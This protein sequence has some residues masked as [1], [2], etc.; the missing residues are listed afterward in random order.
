MDTAWIQVFVLMFAECTAPVGKTVCQEQQFKLQFLNKA[1]CEY[2][3][4]QLISMKN[5]ADYVIVNRQKSVCASSVVEVET[6]A[7]LEGINAAII[8]AD[9]WRLSNQADVRSTVAD[10]DHRDRLAALKSC[11]ETDGE[12]PCK[13]GDIIIEEA[14]GDTVEVWKQE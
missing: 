13:I 5:A 9:G 12:A 2:A 3:L 11:E 14:A 8:E 4:Q 1:D 7:S 6:F 10:T